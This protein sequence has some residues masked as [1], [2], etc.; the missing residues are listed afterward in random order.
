MAYLGDAVWELHVRRS[1]LAE[2]HA[3]LA[4]LHRRAVGTV[5]AA[6]QAAA[7]SAIEPL[8]TAEE[9]EVVRRGRNAKNHAPRGVDP[10]DYRYSTAFECLLGYL[11]YTGQ[12]RRLE[13]VLRLAAG[14]L[15]E[16]GAGAGCRDGT[17][18]GRRAGG[19]AGEEGAGH[20]S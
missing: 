13:E 1:L 12:A 8:L 11:Y 4:D 15:A 2:G 9:K 3:K 7:L 17:Q 19:R 14:A 20:E 5:Q 10:L 16:A 18:A 6:A